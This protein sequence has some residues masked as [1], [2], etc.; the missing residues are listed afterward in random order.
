MR[1]KNDDTTT[2]VV[3]NMYSLACACIV[4][5]QFYVFVERWIIVVIVA[6]T[7]VLPV[8]AGDYCQI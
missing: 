5:V 2:E 4:L 3:V 7:D 6:L 8:F 1:Y